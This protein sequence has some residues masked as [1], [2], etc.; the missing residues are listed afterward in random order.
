[1]AS[2]KFTKNGTIGPML[3]DNVPLI[4]KAGKGGE[5]HSSFLKD[6]G[7]Q[8]GGPDGGNGAREEVS[9]SKDQP[10]LMISGNSAL[11]KR[12]RL[13]SEVTEEEI[14]CMVESA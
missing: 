4:I 7:N 12:L 1:V 11:K 8:H 2:G 13:K 9:I 3:V 14:K 10:M 5:G 6:A